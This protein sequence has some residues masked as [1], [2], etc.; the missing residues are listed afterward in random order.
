M[1]QKYNEL[2]IE[3]GLIMNTIIKDIGDFIFIEHIPEQAD[4]IMV[5]GGSHPE[6]GEKAAE[7][8]KDGA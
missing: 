6:L 4:A 1:E 8:W 5:V 2:I 7:L 3:G